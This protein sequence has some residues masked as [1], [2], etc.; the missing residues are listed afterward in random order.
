LRY[1][2]N[3]IVYFQTPDVAKTLDRSVYTIQ[4]WCRQNRFEGAKKLGRDYVIP[5]KSIRR[6]KTAIEPQTPAPE[7]TIR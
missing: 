1:Q 2:L 4:K 6:M 7:E 5:E 3:G